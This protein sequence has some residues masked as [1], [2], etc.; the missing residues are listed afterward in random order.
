MLKPKEV[1]VFHSFQL[2]GIAKEVVVD[3][4]LD[5]W[6]GEEMFVLDNE[7][8]VDIAV[9]REV[10]GCVLKKVVVKLAPR[11]FDQGDGDVAEGR[12]ELGANPS[13]S[14]LFVCVVA[15]PENT[16]V[17]CKGDNGSDV[18]CVPCV[19]CLVPTWE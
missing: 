15:C 19:G 9:V 1:K 8:V 16:S 3:E 14:N 13:L 5:G 4:G 10:E 2:D 18:G 11:V 6:V 7:A 12:R 17:E